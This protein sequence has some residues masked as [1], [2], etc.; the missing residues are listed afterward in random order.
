M[1]SF[2]PIL[3]CAVCRHPQQWCGSGGNGARGRPAPEPVVLKSAYRTEPACKELLIQFLLS[4]SSFIF[5]FLFFLFFSL[6]FFLRIIVIVVN[7]EMGRVMVHR[8]SFDRVQ[9]K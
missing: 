5:F 6:F 8:S 7:A 4:F 9:M 1:S 3:Q 2:D